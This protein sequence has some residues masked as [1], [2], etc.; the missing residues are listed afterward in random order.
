LQHEPKIGGKTLAR[1]LRMVK[2]TALSCGA[3]VTCRRPI[4]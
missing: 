1:G 2:M 4:P 3:T